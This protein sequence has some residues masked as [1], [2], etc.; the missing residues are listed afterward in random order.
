LHVL[1]LAKASQNIIIYFFNI[2]FIE[3]KLRN[4]R[5][6]KTMQE[7]LQILL[8]IGVYPLSILAIAGLISAIIINKGLRE[9]KPVKYNN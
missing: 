9:Y 6:T 1:C 8:V 3:L 5:R 4:Q 7:Y 2:T